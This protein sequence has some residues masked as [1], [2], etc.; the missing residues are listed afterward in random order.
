MI[1]YFLEVTIAWTLFYALFQL[2]LKRETFF[3]INRWYLLVTLIAGA[4]MPLLRNLPFGYTASEPLI[5]ESVNAINY[6]TQVLSESINVSHETSG[7]NF[8]KILT[9]IY[10]LG[11]L[12]FTINMCM[13]LKRIWNIYAN[14]T[15]QV[16]E[17]ITLIISSDYHLPF[18]F[19]QKVFIHESFLESPA[20][21]KIL[22]H[23]YIHI[24]DHHTYDVI[25][26]EV[27]SILFWWNPLI[28]LYKGS[29]KQTHEYLADAYA[30]QQSHIKEYGRILLHQ[31][32]SGIELALTNQ[33]F[34]SHLKKR[35]QMLN[36][37]KSVKLKLGKYLLVIPILLFLSVLYSF[38]LINE[39]QLLK[40][41]IKTD[42]VSSDINTSLLQTL[43]ENERVTLNEIQKSSKA[44]LISGEEKDSEIQNRA[45]QEVE[46]SKMS[47]N[48]FEEE[49]SEK[50]NIFP[51]ECKPIKGS[52][53]YVNFFTTTPSILKTCD[54]LP[55]GEC[56]N[57]C[58]RSTIAE[59]IRPLIEY[60]DEAIQKGYQ[61]SIHYNI[62]VD[63]KGEIMEIR[64]EEIVRESFGIAERGKK[65]LENLDLEFIPGTCDGQVVKTLFGVMLKFRLSPEQ[66]SM[67]PARTGSNTNNINQ[68]ISFQGASANGRIGFSMHSNLSPNTK[69]TIID[70]DG[71]TVMEK[72][73][74]YFY[75][76]RWDG[77]ALDNPKNGN[78]TAIMVQDGK[79]VRS[80]MNVTVFNE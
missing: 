47:Q 49:A 9:Y 69:V 30:T 57:S 73:Y 1:Q 17:N 28:Y 79:E 43:Q 56:P 3:S 75:E 77:V 15:K 34:N 22:K 41:E 46:D 76:S 40:D 80:E 39:P 5:L 67:M 31:G 13:G 10:G 38:K 27:M 62:V 55:E 26:M 8:Q 53:V 48:N 51:I 45:D 58:T 19:L 21:H 33:F 42:Q 12:F 29:I 54:G 71:N 65:V 24:K 68:H 44:S 14:G 63:E 60:T 59:I 18:S 35:I 37:K 70:P 23:E 4:L 2:F 11:V 16:F 6:G 36:K 66:L 50:Q 20:L 7:I 64:P 32:I 74:E 52:D 61:G 72:E 25:F 78:Y